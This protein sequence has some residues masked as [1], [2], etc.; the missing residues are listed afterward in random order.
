MPMTFPSADGTPTSDNLSKFM[1]SSVGVGLLFIVVAALVIF[2]W[3]RRKK[4]K[5]NHPVNNEVSRDFSCFLFLFARFLLLLLFCFVLFCFVFL[6]VF[7]FLPFF[8]SCS[9]LLFLFFDL[10]FMYLSFLYSP[11]KVVIIYFEDLNLVFL[12]RGESLE[13]LILTF[14]RFTL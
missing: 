12:E 9:L 13:L 7:S 5:T 8:L 14:E 2:K 11:F 1:W 10:C 4:R 6:V 3:R